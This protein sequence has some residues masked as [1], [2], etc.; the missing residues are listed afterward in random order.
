VGV[1]PD[2][3]LPRAP[4]GRRRPSGPIADLGAVAGARARLKALKA[5]IFSSGY[6]GLRT[7]RGADSYQEEGADHDDE[8][9][10]VLVVMGW[11]YGVAQIWA[12]THLEKN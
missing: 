7:L 9:L 2:G 4:E 10:A 11:A 3:G 1:G 8:F 5:L 6:Y 12:W